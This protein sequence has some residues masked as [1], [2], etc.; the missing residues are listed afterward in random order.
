[1]KYWIDL[2]TYSAV[3]IG[4]C[5]L[6]RYVEDPSFEIL[7]FAYGMDDS[8]VRVVD[9]AGGEELP[10]VF[11]DA[12]YSPLFTKVAYNAQ[13]EM[14][15]L[16]KVFG[17]M[18]PA[19]WRCA[20]AKGLY[21]GYPAGLDA[22]GAAL[23]LRDDE[24]KLRTG[25]DLI[26][27]FCRP[28]KP[29]K[30]NGGRTRNMPGD[31]PDKWEMFKE[32]CQ[33][34]VE[35][36]RAIARRLQTIEPPA[37]FWQEWRTDYRVA[38]RGVGVD[39]GL[40]GGALAMAE[41]NNES[42]ME[43]AAG[44]TGLE[45]PNSRDQMLAWLNGKLP[46]PVADIRKDTVDELLKADGL[47]G[48]VRRALEIRQELGKT[49]TKKYDALADCTGADGRV[50]GLLQFYGASRTGRFAGRLVQV[51][52]LPRTYI[53]DTD[54]ARELVRNVDLEGV[55]REFG[56]PSST[57]SQL[58]RTAL[59]PAPGN[60]F[61]DADFSAIEARVLSWMSGE[62]WRLDVFRGAGKIYEATASQMFGVPVERIAK[63]NPEYA[64]RA[65][66]KIGELACGYGGG[67]GAL[68]A[69]G[70]LE[71]GL[72]EEE[73]AEVV[74]KWRRAN[75]KI[76]D[77]W[78]EVDDAATK[79]VKTKRPQ[80]VPCY[81]EHD[82]SVRF[83]FRCE[84]HGGIEYMRVVLPSGRSLYYK[85]P[86]IGVNRFGSPS[87]TFR[88]VGIT[89]K[90]ETL[91][92]FGGKLVENLTQAT[93]RDC[94]TWKMEDIEAAGYPVVFHVHDEVVIDHDPARGDPEAA[95]EDVVRI[96]SEP[97]P[98]AKR[99]PLSAAGWTG[100]YFTKD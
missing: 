74:A 72:T 24:K 10:Q 65:K 100:D 53:K 18:D 97:L 51:Q 27:Y 86:G 68:K 36:E 57:L 81:G 90:W 79:C 34:D 42:L 50:R 92:T 17:P 19:Q 71:M 69:M 91:E 40:V 33:R 83:T 32:Y 78:R 4:S 14:A 11:I 80:H 73:L 41:K 49:S 75:K 87:I 64:L 62:E 35:T 77:L 76:V 84:S 29:T 28:C 20:M 45:N 48:D 82:P 38:T 12:L 52:N 16:G 60:K 21:C 54:R 63:G 5:G 30:A 1:M 96:M 9:L 61:V 25:R 67:A 47:P 89:H 43:E 66:G 22:I 7:L 56:S 85:D 2:E 99:L 26:R 37:R 70:A 31:A 59:I 15:C 44:L 8:P 6:Y 13:F 39:L 55:K 94:L 98:W 58:I 95:L 3:D 93:A 23:G 88:G 46:S